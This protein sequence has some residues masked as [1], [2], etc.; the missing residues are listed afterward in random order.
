MNK[1]FTEIFSKAPLET[2]NGDWFYL[3]DFDK[4]L[5]AQLRNVL[6]G[7]NYHEAK[8]QRIQSSFTENW[9]QRTLSNSAWPWT[10]DAVVIDVLRKIADEGTPIMDIASSE[11]MGLASYI[12]KL[13]PAIPCL[14]TDIDTFGMKCLR[15]CIDRDLPEYNI[16]IASF[17]ST[18]MPIKD[19]SLDCITSISGMDSSAKRNG[20]QPYRFSAG[21]EDGSMKYTAS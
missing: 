4:E 9:K 17:D 6:D 10:K 1:I 8:Q 16:S 3:A 5:I 15:E 21:K 13:N 19:C 20:H 2:V 12:L 11:A 7:R 18:A 14:I